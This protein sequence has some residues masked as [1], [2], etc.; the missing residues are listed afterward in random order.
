V[1]PAVVVG[2]LT[3]AFHL[4][5][6][7]VWGFHRDEFYYLACSRRLAWG[8]VDHPPITPALFRV[9]ELLFGASQVGLRVAPAL[10]HGA[11]VVVTALLAKELGAGSRGQLLAALAA[12]VCPMFLTTGH[13][14]GTVT[15]EVLSCAVITLL[16]VK[17]VHG[18]DP[19]LWLA[20][21]AA[22]GI[23]LLNKWTVTYLV[24]ALV[25]G[26]LLSPSR[27]VL[28]S[29]WVVAGAAVALLLWSP[30][31]SWQASHDWPA[32]AFA[33]RIRD[34]GEAMLT[35]P[36]QLLFAG[37]AAVLA[38]V[39]LVR[40][41]ERW[42]VVAFAVVVVVV[43]ATGGKPY[44]AG[45]LL[46][47]LIGAGAVVAEAWRPGPTFAAIGLLALVMAPFSMPL[48]P[49]STAGFLARLNPELGEMLG[50]PEVVAEIERVAVAHPGATVLTVTYSEAGALELWSP[51]LRPISA[52]LTYWYWA[53]LPPGRSD[54]TIVVAPDRAY[55][56]RFWDD[57]EH[58]A[59]LG[60]F[61]MIDD[62]WGVFVARD[63]RLD[64][65][66]LWP[67]LQRY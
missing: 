18:A 25:A 16:V 19:R 22:V 52:H 32:F 60:P 58:V 61:P 38:V 12:A 45:V 57:V 59:T 62:G 40:T 4:A 2:V 13:F 53:E 7:G 63:Q 5:T 64:W 47:A 54:T 49:R 11:T 51:A 27:D 9:Q 43:M 34:Y 8:F 21:G 23:A 33:A 3:A 67:E 14:L 39:G 46:P 37:P 35:L 65:D 6:A 10:I 66:E 30:N 36:Y 1:T 50:W 31:L 17:L 29:P 56:D 20:V 48:T 44:Y 41:P 24:L 15:F 55:V 28:F 26:L 42:L